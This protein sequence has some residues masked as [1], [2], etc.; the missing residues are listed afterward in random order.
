MNRGDSNKNGLS[1]FAM[2][3]S[4]YREIEMI[5]RSQVEGVSEAILELAHNP[6]PDR[7]CTLEDCRGCY[8]LESNG[9]YILYHLSDKEDALTVLGVLDGPDHTLH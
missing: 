4:A 3:Y 1:G 9:Y 2:T 8:Y 7:A 6:K 5:P